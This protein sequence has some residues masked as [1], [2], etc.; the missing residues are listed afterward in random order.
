V[1][2]TRAIEAVAENPGCL[3]IFIINA[4][5]TQGQLLQNTDPL[6]IDTELLTEPGIWSKYSFS[7]FHL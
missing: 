3:T 4:W 7:R 2:G 6:P 1:H 5:E